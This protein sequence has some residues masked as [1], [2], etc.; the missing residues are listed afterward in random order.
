MRSFAA[1]TMYVWYGKFLTVI[2]DPTFLQAAWITGFSY[3]RFKFGLFIA[4]LYPVSS[5]PW[6]PL[7]STVI[8]PTRPPH[9][10]TC[11]L[12]LLAM[13][14]TRTSYTSRLHTCIPAAQQSS[15]PPCLF[16]S[17]I[18]LI[19]TMMMIIIIVRIAVVIILIIIMIVIAHFQSDD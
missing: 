15:V 2:K 1:F 13:H 5:F 16:Y 11:V 4:L 7:P 3:S 17:N 10:P 18:I 6:P 9:G 12:S 8:M 14:M 19:L